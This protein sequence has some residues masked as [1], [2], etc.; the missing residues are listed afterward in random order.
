MIGGEFNGVTD[1]VICLKGE[2]RPIGTIGKIGVWSGEEI[3]FLLNRTY[4]HRGLAVE[5]MNG[6]LPFLF[7][8]KKFEWLVADVD[9][10]NEASIGLLKKFGFE[11]DK[12]EERALEV[13]GEWV[14]SLYLKLTKERWEA[15]QSS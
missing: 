15:V 8:R 9:P 6:I 5:A 12:L 3:G 13:D 1:F 2:D 11:V 10:R 4:W 7:E 14:D